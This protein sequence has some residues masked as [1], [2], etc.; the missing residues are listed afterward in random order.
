MLP[1]KFDYADQQRIAKLEAAN[2]ALRAALEAA[3]SE[4]DMLHLA[5]YQRDDITNI[6]NSDEYKEY[7]AWCEDNRSEKL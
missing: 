2:S 3:K 7:M 1:N 4:I 6:V 5:M